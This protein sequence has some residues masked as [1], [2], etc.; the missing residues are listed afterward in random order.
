[1]VSTFMPR[2]IQ[3]TNAIG[4]GRDQAVDRHEQGNTTLELTTMSQN[5]E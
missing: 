3:Y 1:M 2:L 4:S 5:Y